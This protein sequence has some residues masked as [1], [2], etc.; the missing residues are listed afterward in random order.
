M[1][2]GRQDAPPPEQRRSQKKGALRFVQ[3]LS[4][5]Q[6]EQTVAQEAK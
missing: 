4:C 3:R 5:F 6:D 2:H 1:A